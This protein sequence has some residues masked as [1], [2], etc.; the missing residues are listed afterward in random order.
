MVVTLLAGCGGLP[1]NA[2]ARISSEL[3][4]RQTLLQR[5][6]F[7]DRH[8]R[9]CAP[10]LPDRHDGVGHFLAVHRS[11]DEHHIH[12]ALT[13]RT[14]DALQIDGH[15]VHTARIN[16][17]VP[18]DGL[19]HAHVFHAASDH[20]NPLAGKIGDLAHRHAREREDRDHAG[21]QDDHRLPGK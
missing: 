18:Q 12:R 7:A 15:Q 14:V 13:H 4:D 20:A 8:E 5:L 11:D 2:P 3:V 19:Q 16:A 17:V 9:W 10:L 21:A 1:P 6:G